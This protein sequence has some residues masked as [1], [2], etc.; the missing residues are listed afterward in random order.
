MTEAQTH[1]L[2]GVPEHYKRIFERAY[3]GNSRAMALKA[4]CL[5]CTG[6]SRG[7]ITDCTARGCPLYPYRPYQAGDTEDSE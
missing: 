3:G 4:F 2:T 7:D 1:K 5:E 6:F